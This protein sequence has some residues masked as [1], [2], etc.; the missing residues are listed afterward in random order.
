MPYP[1]VVLDDAT[2]IAKDS[3]AAWSSGEVAD[4]EA[5]YAS[6]A[7]LETAPGQTFQGLD[8]ITAAAT[9]VPSGFE[10]EMTGDVTVSPGDAFV[11]HPY[12]VTTTSAGAE[13]GVIV[14][15]LEDGLIVE[16]VHHTL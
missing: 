2:S 15:Q 12:R 3:V 5:A 14:L 9:G 11:A 8:E 10:L 7:V 4:F 13:A 16:E 1:K 6:D